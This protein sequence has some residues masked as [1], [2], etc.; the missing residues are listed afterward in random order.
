ML[1]L[2]YGEEEILRIPQK[3]MVRF[4]FFFLNMDKADLCLS[5]RPHQLQD[6]CFLRIALKFFYRPN[7]FSHPDSKIVFI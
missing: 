3:H 1:H 6:L 4:N 7:D 2:F 5:F